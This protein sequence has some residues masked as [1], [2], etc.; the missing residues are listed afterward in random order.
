MKRE[1]KRNAFH[2]CLGF[3]RKK[4]RRKSRKPNQ[5]EFRELKTSGYPVSGNRNKDKRSELKH[6]S[7]S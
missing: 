3:L 6:L 7:N 1:S 5:I 2:G 4:G